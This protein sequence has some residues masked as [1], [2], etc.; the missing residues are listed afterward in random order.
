MGFLELLASADDLGPHGD[1]KIVGTLA[2]THPEILA[3]TIEAV[4]RS[5]S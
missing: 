5:V 1:A 2:I 3:E 4:K